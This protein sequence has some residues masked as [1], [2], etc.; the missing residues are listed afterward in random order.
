MTASPAS[1]ANGSLRADVK[2]AILWRSGSQIAAQAVAWCSTLA[3]IRILDP[4]DYG[5]FAMT[6][7]I[8]VFLSFLNGYGFASSLVQDREMDMRKV[9]QAFDMMLIL[10]ATIALIQF[11]LA[12]VAA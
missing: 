8:L 1:P 10:N 6:Q 7:V 2:A 12:P 9:R 5:I 4:S 11:A 3:V